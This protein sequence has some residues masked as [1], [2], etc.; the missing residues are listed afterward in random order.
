MPIIVEINL[1]KKLLNTLRPLLTLMG[2]IFNKNKNKLAEEEEEPNHML[3]IIIFSKLDFW[4]FH[5]IIQ[6]I[7]SL[8]SIIKFNKYKYSY[9]YRYIL[10]YKNMLIC[11]IN[12][13][14]QK[15]RHFSCPFYCHLRLQLDQLNHLY[16]SFC[17]LLT[18]HL[19]S[20]NLFFVVRAH[21]NCTMA[22]IF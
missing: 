13:C 3:K 20:I 15:N 4:N 14:L 16:F 1:I 21:Y 19:N 18:N 17:L 7:L 2:L 9:R 6:T 5:N 8:I 12:P 10:K 11:I 22:I